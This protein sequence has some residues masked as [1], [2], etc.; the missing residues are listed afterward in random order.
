[1]QVAIVNIKGGAIVEL[2]TLLTCFDTML[3]YCRIDYAGRE[4]RT[5]I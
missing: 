4:I 2:I 1:M 3:D 5:L